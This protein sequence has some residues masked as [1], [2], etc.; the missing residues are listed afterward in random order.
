MKLLRRAWAGAVAG[1]PR[2]RLPKRLRAVEEVL[3]AIAF[4]I[5]CGAVLF[6]TH[7]KVTI[8]DSG[9]RPEVRCKWCQAAFERSPVS[10]RKR[11]HQVGG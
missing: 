3:S 6:I 10:A 5:G 9:K 11:I 7:P 2:L 1:C 4:C 8:T